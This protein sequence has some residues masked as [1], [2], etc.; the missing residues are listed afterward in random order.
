MIRHTLHSAGLALLLG[1]TL[2]AGCGTP[3]ASREAPGTGG[4][5]MAPSDTG[6]GTGSSQRDAIA[7]YI[8]KLPD[9]DFVETYGDDDNPRP[10]YTAAEALGGIG[11]DAVPALV[12][13]LDTT[14]PY[15][16][17]LA[18]YA[19]MLASQDPVLQAETGGEYLRLGVVLTEEGNEDNL[20]KARSWWERHR[21]LWP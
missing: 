12:E 10:W 7:Y 11:K 4:A 17:K 14:D 1:T 6:H 19:L 16:L 13:R 8:E 15:E 2:L 5:D 3:E 20:R 18:L 9:R 21:H